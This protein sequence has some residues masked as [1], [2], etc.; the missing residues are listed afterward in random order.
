MKHVEI[1]KFFI[2]EKIVNGVLKLKYVK[3]R[4]QLGD[5]LTKGLS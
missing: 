4:S 2:K 3:S 5:G 1:D